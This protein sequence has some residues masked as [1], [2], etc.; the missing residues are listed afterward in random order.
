M[1]AYTPIE[2]KT[3]LPKLDGQ[4]SVDTTLFKNFIGSLRYFTCTRLDI[5]FAVVFGSY[6]MEKPSEVHMKTKKRILWYIQR[7]C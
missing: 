1:Q 5:S 3:N 7:T 4:A 6:F 2:C